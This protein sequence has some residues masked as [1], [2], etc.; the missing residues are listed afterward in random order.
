[1]NLEA[2]I[3][4]TLK[5]SIVLSVIAIGL[6]ARLGDAIHLLRH[7]SLLVRSLLAMDVIMPIFAAA[8]VGIFALN[9]AV[10][11]VLVALAVSP[12]PPLL[13]NRQLKAEGDPSYTIGLLVLS[14]VVAIV[15]IPIAVKYLGGFLDVRASMTTWPI[16]KLAGVT[17]LAPLVAGMLVHRFAPAIAQRLLRPVALFSGILLLLCLLPVLFTA[18]PSI[19][20]LIGNGTV[21]AIAAF[22]IVGLAVGHWLGGP[23]PHD[24]AVLAL[25]TATRHPAIALTIGTTNFPDQKAI[26]PA[27]L[28][29]AIIGAIVS[30]P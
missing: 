14:A 10:E 3:F 1:M 12:V 7:P 19:I 28:L 24:R 30:L 9:P 5:A 13:P 20:A 2:L 25:A 27:I 21:V 15:F 4:N 17:I 6:S 26:L 11:V 8:V 29:Y 18:L 22:V 23:D 16:A